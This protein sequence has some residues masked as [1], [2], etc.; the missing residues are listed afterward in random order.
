MSHLTRPRIHFKGRLCA[1]VTTANN[2]D[3]LDIIDVENVTTYPHDWMKV[4]DQFRRWATEI[5]PEIAMD[6]A[7][8]R[9]RAG[10]NYYGT[11]KCSLENVTITSFQ[12][13][14]DPLFTGQNNKSNL[15]Q[16]PIEKTGSI[17]EGA[18]S[19]SRLDPLLGATV[20]FNKAIMI[21]VD[22][23]SIFSSQIFYDGFRIKD[24]NDTLF[25]ADTSTPFYACWHHSWRNLTFPRQFTGAS[26]VW[27]GGIPSSKLWFNPNS[28]SPALEALDV[29]GKK[30]EGLF[31][32]FCTYFFRYKYTD[33]ELV[34]KFKQGLAESNPACGYVVGTIGPWNCEEMASLMATGRFLIAANTLP[35]NSGETFPLG[36][37][38][39]QVIEAEGRQYIAL[40]LISTFPEQDETREKAPL[41]KFSLQLRSPKKNL[42]QPKNLGSVSYDRK[43]Y[44]TGGGIVEVE[45]PSTMEAKDLAEGTLELFSEKAEF[46]T[47]QEAD[48]TI[49]IDQLGFYLNAGR[50]PQEFKLRVLRRG[51]LVEEPVQIKFEQYIMTNIHRLDK[52]A[53]LPTKKDSAEAK[54]ALP[55][56]Y[57]VEI[58][59]DRMQDD[60]ITVEPN[61]ICKVTL[62]GIKPGTC[63]IRFVDAHRST[64]DFLRKFTTSFFINVRVFPIDDYSYMRDDELTFDLIYREVL[65]YFYLLYSPHDFPHHPFDLKDEESMKHHA[66]HIRARITK[67]IH[68]VDYM[69]RTRDLSE[70]KRRLLLRWCNKVCPPKNEIAS[71]SS[72]REVASDKL[73]PVQKS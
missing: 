18:S 51:Q 31:I 39:A 68:E 2:D 47:L 20:D 48:L 21:D 57:I 40:D 25:W 13:P 72:V 22:P 9:I 11:G 37:A 33:E 65:R 71:E 58:K 41:G 30:G 24:K 59:A 49:A 7:E 44:E 69:P 5:D 1:N 28:N 50:D 12:L 19:S 70:G 63:I 34:E 3:V 36:S 35:Y 14:G 60:I 42:D 73:G 61:G 62:T 10:R 53:I 56:E 32:R 45:I 46:V 67:E 17:P 38:I 23:E 4:E 6:R 29:A 16:V 43:T 52:K 64:S 54:K 66:E 15:R 27:Y 8:K 55:E 26:A